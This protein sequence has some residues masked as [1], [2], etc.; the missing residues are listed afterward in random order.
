MSERLISA[1]DV[2]LKT[3][4]DSYQQAARPNPGQ[5]LVD[6]VEGAEKDKTIA[7]MR[8]NHTG[9]VCAQALYAG[10]ALFARD[11]STRAQMKHSAAEEVDHLVWCHQQLNQ[12][13]GSTSKL[14]PL[15]YA[16]SFALGA[17][18]ALVSDKTSLGFVHATEENVEAHLNDHLERL[19]AGAKS[20]R[21][22]VEQMKQ[23]E[24]EHGQAALAHGGAKL[25]K[26][27]RLGMKQVA[28][29]MTATAYRI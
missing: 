7:L 5:A 26:P 28:K 22:V 17:T 8:V 4:T 24:A 19:P 23:D 21:A 12:M 15:F 29:L 10:Q 9:E 20:S 6:Q 1:L 16:A 11:P 13:G 2:G 25:P 3:L 27:I 18:A 14:N